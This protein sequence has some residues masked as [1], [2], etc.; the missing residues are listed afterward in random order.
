MYKRQCIYDLKREKNSSHIFKNKREKEI[1]IH[2][3]QKK[4]IPHIQKGEEIIVHTNR[5]SDFLVLYQTKRGREFRPP[6]IKISNIF[7][8]TL[9]IFLSWL[10]FCRNQLNQKV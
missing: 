3:L 5:G 2:P 1:Q 9:N 4:D 8:L 7:C 6:L 10:I